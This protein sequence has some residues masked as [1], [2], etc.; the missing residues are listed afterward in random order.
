MEC[1]Y[2]LAMGAYRE[3]VIDI[4]W[5]KIPIFSRGSSKKFPPRIFLLDCV[6]VFRT[7][8]RVLSLPPSSFANMLDL[9]QGRNSSCY[10]LTVHYTYYYDCRDACRRMHKHIRAH[11]DTDTC[12]DGCTH[13]VIWQLKLISY[14]WRMIAKMSFTLDCNFFPKKFLGGMALHYTN[15]QMHA[16]TYMDEPAHI[17]ISMRTQPGSFLLSLSWLPK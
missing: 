12:M 5:S 10:L 4:R 14:S 1:N 16:D 11:T 13:N 7:L 15:V 2:A 6:R 8:P 17:Y 9:L 3:D